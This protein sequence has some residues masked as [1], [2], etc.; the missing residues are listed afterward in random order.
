MAKIIISILIFISFKAD[1]QVAMFHAHNQAPTALPDTFLLNDF[2][3]ALSAY[4][5]RR[6]NS[7]Y[8]GSAIRVL[9]SSDLT[10]LDI[11]FTTAGDLDTAT[12]KTFVGAGT[13]AVTIWYDQSGNG[14][15]AATGINNIATNPYIIL[16]GVVQREG[17]RP[18]INYGATGANSFKQINN[19]TSTTQISFFT[20]AKIR[21]AGTNF[22]RLLSG[23]V[24]TNASVTYFFMGTNASEQVTTFY[25]NG[26]TWGTTSTQSTTSWLTWRLVTSINNGNDNQYVNGSLINSRSNAMGAWTGR[27]WIGGDYGISTNQRWFGTVSEVIV[28]ASD[29]SANRTGIESKINNYYNIY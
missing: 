24:S 18:A 6:L 15:N 28:Y 23:E 21:T 12:M 22:Q 1:A 27:M 8:L 26:T 11:G 16:S 4:S 17:T 20:T 13:G 19:N 2:P 29:K 9:R 7:T 5:L 10:S 14:N 3:T 25:G